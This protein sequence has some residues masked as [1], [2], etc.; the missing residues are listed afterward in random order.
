MSSSS[1]ITTTSCRP[2]P[3]PQVNS[4]AGYQPNQ[5]ERHNATLDP[6]VHARFGLIRPNYVSS[7]SFALGRRTSS[8]VPIP[9]SFS[10]Q[11]FSATP[12]HR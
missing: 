2:N 10:P 6:A 9:A 8:V 4:T 12:H 3:H 5:Q 11:D 7:V 1:P